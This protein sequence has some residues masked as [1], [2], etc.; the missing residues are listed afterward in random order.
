MKNNNIQVISK[1]LKD[2]EIANFR[3][4]EVHQLGYVPGTK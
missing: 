1:E 4:Y 2:G 3:F